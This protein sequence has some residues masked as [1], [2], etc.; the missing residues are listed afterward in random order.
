MGVFRQTF[1]ADVARFVAHLPA[2]VLLP[3][4]AKKEALNYKAS[5]C[6]IEWARTIDPHD[7]NVVL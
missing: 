6:G 7:V 4:K 2:T 5:R 1:E 3:R